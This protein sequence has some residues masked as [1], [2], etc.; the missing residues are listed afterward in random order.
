MKLRTFFVLWLFALPPGVYAGEPL[1]EWTRGAVWYHLVPERFRNGNPNNDPSKQEVVGKD[2]KDWQIHPWASDWYKLQIWEENRGLSFDELVAQRRYGGDLFGVLEKLPYLKELGVNV[3][4]L[5]PVFE[6]PSILKFNASTLH[7]IDDNFGV[8]SD[9]GGRSFPLNGRNRPPKNKASEE[10][11]KL[12]EPAVPETEDP[13]TWKLT[14]TDELFVE[15]LTKARE[16]GMKV[17]MSSA[18]HYCGKDFWAFRDLREKQQKSSYKD[19]FEVLSWDDPATPDT[20]EF[21]C[22]SWQDDRNFPLFR[23]DEHGLVEPLKKYI[24][25]S[26]RRWLDPNGDGDPADGVDGWALYDAHALDSAF[27]D[28]WVK[29]VKSINPNA[30]TFAESVNDAPAIASR[31]DLIISD[32]FTQTVHDF[33]IHQNYTLSEFEKKLASSPGND[34]AEAHSV[35]HRLSD[36]RSDRIATMIRTAVSSDSNRAAPQNSHGYDPRKPDKR[37]RD[38][39]KALVFLQLTYPG[40]PM[41]FYGDESGMWGGARRDLIKPMLW[42]EFVYEKETYSTIRPDLSDQCENAVD[43][44]LLRLYWQLNKIRRENPALQKGEYKL[45]LADDEKN[46]LAFTRQFDRNEVLVVFNHGDVRQTL[47]IGV[48]WKDDSKVKDEFKD[49]KMR[50]QN[51]KVKVELEKKTGTV[52]IKLK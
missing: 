42:K 36:H 35:I 29:L 25:D 26:T 11:A 28:E 15:L 33:F 13:K 5:S 24:F 6:S 3:I 43:E 18:F 52:L 21:A 17:V 48:S 7:H 10:K 19:W 46:I 41:I 51:G 30:V 16:Q 50:V 4:Y 1:P 14:P 8:A 39:Q 45:V 9:S 31:F 12:E 47:E 38:I 37:H 34:S 20:V 2:R 27:V 44:E 49:Q 40:A 22:K 32:D 23:K